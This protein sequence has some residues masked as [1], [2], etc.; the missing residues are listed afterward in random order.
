MYFTAGYDM[1]TFKEIY[2]ES[3]VGK[4]SMKKER[5]YNIEFL[6]VICCI[7]VIYI[8]VANYYCRGYGEIS[9]SSYIFSM[10]VNGLCRV[11][12]PIFFMISGALLIDEVLLIKKSIRR[13]IKMFGSLLFWSLLYY[14]WNIF[15]LDRYYDFREIFYAPVKRH[16]WFLYAL[17]GIYMILPFLQ[18]MLK[19]MPKMLMKYFVV[20]WIIFLT[21]SYI[22]ALLKLE[23]T[24]AVPLFGSS[25]YLGYFIMGYIIHSHI[26]SI[27][28]NKR[29]C[30]F[31]T[32]VA[33]CGTLLATGLCTKIKGRHSESFFE[34]R[35]ILIA[36]ASVMVFILVL[37]WRKRQYSD[38]QKSVMVH[39]SKYSFTI[40][41]VHILFLDF[42]KH[43]MHPRSIHSVIGLP[44]FAT[45]IFIASWLFS[46]LYHTLLKLIKGGR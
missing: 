12:V 31:V 25:V 45:G 27:Y 5:D 23:I 11:S 34:Y 41:L 38:R 28:L 4:S 42:V 39:L 20:L 19:D 17:L 46:I 10:I 37:K 13:T 1:M 8:H 18:Y 29:T 9:E 7:M 21:I 26:D 3:H 44:L 33:L 15:Y 22:S 14:V 16:L 30:W 43:E 40:Y 6:R 35:S 24:Y 36:L 32:G 2:R